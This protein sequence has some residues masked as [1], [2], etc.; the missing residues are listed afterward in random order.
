MESKKPAVSPQT[1]SPKKEEFPAAMFQP[2]RRH[3]RHALKMPVRAKLISGEWV[4]EAQNISAGGMA[5]AGS[6]REMD[7]QVMLVRFRL[8]GTASDIHATCQVTWTAGDSQAGVR[9]LGM[10]PAAHSTLIK[11]LED[12][13]SQSAGRA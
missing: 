7:S 10:S 5:L 8:P 11:W 3:P 1:G 6:R 13:L 9:F 12:S 4:A 2:A